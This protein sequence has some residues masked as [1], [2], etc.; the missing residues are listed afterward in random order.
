M[1]N[2]LLSQFL[3]ATIMF[4]QASFTAT[5][6][7]RQA[8]STTVQ[9]I[10]ETIK[11]SPAVIV[12]LKKSTCKFCTYISPLIQQLQ[13][14]HP[15]ITFIEIDC[16]TSADIYKNHFNF[17]TFPTVI[18]YKNGQEILRHGSNNGTI[19]LQQMRAYTKTIL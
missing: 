11:S 17:R 15:E 12:Y 19:T 10:E 13:S 16:S 1:Q 7:Y 2:S 8:H 5:H 3:A 4:A 9:A 18:Y 6:I 14:T